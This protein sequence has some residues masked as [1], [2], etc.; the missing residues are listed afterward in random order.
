MDKKKNLD[1][2][3][4]HARGATEGFPPEDADFIVD[5]TATG[6]TLRANNL[7]I[8]DEI[9]SSSTHLYAHPEVLN[10]PAQRE[11]ID[12]FVDILKSVLKARERVLIEFHVPNE[13]ALAI[14]VKRLPAMKQPTVATLYGGAGFSVKIASP[15][16]DLQSILGTIKELGGSDILVMELKHLMN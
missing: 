9:S 16:K 3:I 10:N 12:R 7:E 6:S 11:I 15:R 14:A 13:E 8:I 1:A 2:V 4:V 5:N